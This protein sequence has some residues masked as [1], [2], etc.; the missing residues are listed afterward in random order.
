MYAVAMDFLRRVDLLAKTNRKD[1]SRTAL[2]GAL[3]LC[4][5]VCLTVYLV[6][7]TRSSLRLTQE[8]TTTLFA[9]DI[10]A[11]TAAGGV[12]EGLRVPIRCDARRMYGC[13]V[14]VR[15]DSQDAAMVPCVQQVAQ[16]AQTEC[17]ASPAFIENGTW[18]M[19]GWMAPGQQTR[20]PLCMTNGRLDGVYTWYFTSIL[21]FN[22]SKL[23]TPYEARGSTSQHGDSSSVWNEI[24][25]ASNTLCDTI[26]FSVTSLIDRV[27]NQ[28]TF[29]RQTRLRAESKTCDLCAP[30]TAMYQCTGVLLQSDAL[31]TERVTTRAMG[32]LQ[33]ADRFGGMTALVLLGA[34]SL[35]L[36]AGVAYKWRRWKL[37]RRWWPQRALP[38]RQTTPTASAISLEAIEIKEEEQV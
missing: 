17:R 12:P 25:Y 33:I 20:V 6:F 31:Y 11:S 7:L 18:T 9:Q 32:A 38:S 5:P 13:N 10:G 14:T 3:T 35:V 30:Y 36:V 16:W 19:Q 27:A 28:T 22:F 34:K 8:T 21:D 29:L 1:T 4:I 2:G 37:T 26:L 24:R 15:Y 23:G